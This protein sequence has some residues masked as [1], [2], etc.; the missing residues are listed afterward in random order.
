MKRELEFEGCGLM[1][2]E[3]VRFI[4]KFYSEVIVEFEQRK[5][6]DEYIVK[7]SEGAIRFNSDIIMILSERFELEINSHSLIVKYD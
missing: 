5:N 2:G 7:V 1:S 4:Q 6:F 3:D